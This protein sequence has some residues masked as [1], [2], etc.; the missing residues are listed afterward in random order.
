MHI[1]MFGSFSDC[2][3]A[4]VLYV[5]CV[6]LAVRVREL[7]SPRTIRFVCVCSLIYQIDIPFISAINTYIEFKK[8]CTFHIYFHIYLA[9]KRRP[10]PPGAVVLQMGCCGLRGSYV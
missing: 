5:A 1:R 7:R 8:V 6:R 3:V 10:W 9:R 2:N 4:G